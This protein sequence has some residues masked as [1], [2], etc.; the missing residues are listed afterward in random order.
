MDQSIRASPQTLC[1]AE[2]P[3]FEPHS[4]YTL[5]ISKFWLHY[6]VYWLS[7]QALRQWRG[8]KYGKKDPALDKNINKWFECVKMSLKFT[9]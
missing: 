6:S 4:D 2:L 7:T 9:L 1:R 3:E 5:L 8:E